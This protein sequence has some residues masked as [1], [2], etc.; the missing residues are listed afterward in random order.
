MRRVNHG[1]K[2]VFIFVFVFWRFY[3]NYY[4]FFVLFRNFFR[5]FYLFFYLEFLGSIDCCTVFNVKIGIERRFSFFFVFHL[6]FVFSD[7]LNY[8]SFHAKSFI[9]NVIIESGCSKG[10]VYFLSKLAWF[11]RFVL[12]NFGKFFQIFSLKGS[13]PV[14]YRI[15]Y[16]IFSVS[17]NIFLLGALRKFSVSISL[18]ISG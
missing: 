2:Y 16:R 17:W 3:S 9:R 6:D 14:L 12:W 15:L 18:T 13:F 7:W 4:Y 8:T 11:S 10:S 1:W 5:I